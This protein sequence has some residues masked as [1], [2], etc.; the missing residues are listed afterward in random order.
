[1]TAD[2]SLD[3][4]VRIA[5]NSQ[6]LDAQALERAAARFGTGPARGLAEQLIKSGELT[7][8]QAE[9]L[10]RGHWRGLKI[11]PF[12]ILAP[13]GRG[14]MGTV[15]MA[16]DSR[17]AQ[18]L[19][20]EILVA[21]KVLPPQV[22]KKEKRMLDRFLRELELGQRT[23][24]ANVTRTLAGG[25]CE[26]IHYI[27]M[28]YVPGST[29]RQL[30]EQHG[31]LDVGEAARIF[32]DVAA[33]LAHMHERGMIHRDLKPSNVM[34]TP[35]GEAKILDLGLALVP[36]D[37]RR[38]DLTVVGGKGYILGTMDYIS[39]EQAHDATQ[40]TPRSDLYAL[41]C[42]IYYAVTGSPPFPGGTSK[43]KIRAQRTRAPAAIAELNP[44][45]PR[46][47]TLIVESLMAKDPAGRPPSAMAVRELLLPWSVARKPAVHL[48]VHDAVDAVDRPDEHPDLWKDDSASNGEE[49]QMGL[50]DDGFPQ[51]MLIAAVA[52]GL[53]LFMAVLMLLRR[54]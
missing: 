14:G 29:V 31:P 54:L 1:M 26:G 30:V 22:A 34:V 43:D 16:Q 2:V 33:G 13:L 10:L 8:F 40:V 39:P 47:F 32:A 24:H 36:F 25:E 19:G 44:K 18:E 35:G 28:E 11:G 27:A 12:R 20:D 6:L 41:G 4:F 38:F 9:K 15:Y 23:N 53:V 7:H 52:G 51:S 48:S 42:T 3:T 46:D 45:V 37:P 50:E 21:L 49:G 17:L 5:R